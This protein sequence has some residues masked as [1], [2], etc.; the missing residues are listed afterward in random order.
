[1]GAHDYTVTYGPM[2]KSKVRKEWALQIEDDRAETGG[3]AYAGNATTMHGPVWFEDRKFASYNRAVDF[4]LDNHQKWTGPI[5][6]SYA[7]AYAPTDRELAKRQ[8]LSD[9][10]RASQQK[11]ADMRQKMTKDFYERKSRFVGCQECKSRISIDYMQK[12][13]H[14]LSC[15]VCG[16]SFISK[17]NQDKLTA[18]DIKVAK[19]NDRLALANKPRPSKEF[20]WVVGGWAAC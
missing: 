19:A 1:M 4:V 14:S 10:V 11:L 3:G 20:G 7:I 12:K 6:C 8:K 13:K 9:A 2:S 18:A 5:A 16:H 15:P 17:T